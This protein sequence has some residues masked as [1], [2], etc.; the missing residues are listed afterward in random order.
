VA[1]FLLIFLSYRRKISVAQAALAGFLIFLC[2]NYR[3][4]YQYLVIFIPLA[5]WVA[6]TT[7]FKLEGIF[8]ALMALVP[9][10]W[11]WIF[12]VYFWFYFVQPWNLQV[13]PLMERL[14]FFHMFIPDYAYVTLALVLMALFITY[15]V[16]AYTIWRGPKLMKLKPLNNNQ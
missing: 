5:L 15:I 6:G 10:V 4:N 2:L 12:N 3:I 9:A 14:G 7:K 13:R 1:I 11:L 16:L 8:A